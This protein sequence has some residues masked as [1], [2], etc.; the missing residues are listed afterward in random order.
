LSLDIGAG[1]PTSAN[2][3]S[4]SERIGPMG[5]LQYLYSLNEY[6]GVGVQADYFHFAA[7]DHSILSNTGG[8]VNVRS[9]DNVATLEIMGRY[10]LMPN[11]KFVPYLHSGVGLTYFHQIANGE[12][13]PGSTWADTGSNETRD[14]Q[15]V[16]TVNFAYSIGIGVETSLTNNLV[17][18]LESAWQIFGVSKTTYGTNAINVP[19]VSLRLG[20]HFGQKTPT[21]S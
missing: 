9:W 3:F 13:L 17:L 11:V 1:I 21:A 15:D 19:T 18:G 2:D 5:G 12:P 6:W 16:A 20:W 8:Q 10:N 4:N 7:K 14:L